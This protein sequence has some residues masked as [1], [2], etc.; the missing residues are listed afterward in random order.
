ML[1]KN[2]RRQIFF[3]LGNRNLLHMRCR[4]MYYIN[5][6]LF[7]ATQANFLLLFQISTFPFSP[8]IFQNWMNETK[9]ATNS[10]FNKYGDLIDS[11]IC[12]YS[13]HRYPRNSFALKVARTYL[14]SVLAFDAWFFLMRFIFL[15]LDFL[16]Q[17]CIFPIL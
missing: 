10:N 13:K 3:V 8:A 7:R 15:K 17:R 5:V 12:I 16:C 4:Y 1:R 2:T 11:R 9:T 6:F 14:V